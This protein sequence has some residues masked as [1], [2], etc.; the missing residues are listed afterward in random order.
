MNISQTYS[1]TGIILAGG[2]GQRMGGLDKGLIDYQH[3][4]LIKHVIT[5]LSKQVDKLMINA[6]RNIERYQSFGHPVIEDSLS[7]FCGPL[8]GMYS[9]MQASDTDYI[10][11]APCDSP[12]VSNQLRQRMMEVLLKEQADI[13]VAHDGKRLQPV[14]SLI[15]CRLQNDLKDYLQQ[16]DRKI[17]LWFKRHKLAVVDFSDQ[18][19]SFNNFNSPQDIVESSQPVKSK[20][21][22]IGFSAFSGT[23]KTTLLTQL[24]PALSAKGIEV[25]VIKHAH[26][27]FEVDVPGKDSYRI[28]QAGSQQTLVAS[29]RLLALM[30]T[31]KQDPKLAELIPRINSETVDLILVEGFKQEQFAKIELHRPNLGKP[32]LY[33]KDDTIIAIASDLP[34]ELERKIEQLDINDITA[35]ADYLELFIENWTP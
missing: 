23:G 24:I 27:Q 9:A 19:N 14:F 3:Q 20:I 13:A 17:D 32:L 28:R 4:P 26:H 35:I 5:S 18:V 12:T 25:A 33:T 29:S 2:Q 10:L 16:G 1:V 8:A 11:T 31:M 7:G 30:Q 21:P 6:N 15:P 22:L 34:L